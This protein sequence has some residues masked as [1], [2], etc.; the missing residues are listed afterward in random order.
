MEVEKEKIMRIFF[1]CY[2]KIITDIFLAGILFAA[3]FIFLTLKATTMKNSFLL[4]VQ[5]II[6]SATLF[7]SSPVLAQ[8]PTL[9]FTSF[10]SG[11]SAP[12]DMVHASDGTNRLFI[13]QQGGLIRLF[14]GSLQATPFLD[15]SGVVSQ[16]GGE[17]GLLGLAFHPDYETN[18]Y[19]FVYY[20][21]PNNDNDIVIARYR[22]LATIPMW[23]IRQAALYF[24]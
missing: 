22:T 8:G 18:R 3:H 6:L 4:F 10:L 23:Q 16:E 14:D 7:Y 11:L 20:N 2:G 1:K 21:R 24:W 12:V 19:F 17:M 15:L 9:S 5:A 13:V